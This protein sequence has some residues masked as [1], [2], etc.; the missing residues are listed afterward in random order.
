MTATLI[1]LLVLIMVLGGCSSGSRQG[2]AGSVP[3][4][5]VVVVAAPGSYVVCPGAGMP[6]PQPFPK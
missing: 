4:E 1:L 6:L 5:T 3:C 2:D